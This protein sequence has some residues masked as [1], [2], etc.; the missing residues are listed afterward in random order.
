MKNI[1][2]FLVAAVAMFAAVSCNK[3]LTNNNLFGGEVITF[4]ASLDGADTKAQLVEGKSQWEANDAITVLNGTSGFKFTTASEGASVNFTYDNSK[5]D[6][7]GE[8]F[9][10]VYPASSGYPYSADLGDKTV[11]AYIPTW[12]EAVVDSYHKDAALSV[13]YTDSDALYFMNAVALL[14]FTVQNE[15][16]KNVTFVANDNSAVSGNVKVTLNSDGSQI[17]S[18]EGLPTSDLAYNVVYL[19]PNAWTSDDA[20]FAAYFFGASGNEWQ[21]MSDSDGDGVYEVAIPA[22]KNYSSVIFCRMK[23]DAKVNNWDNKWN[24]TVDLSLASGQIF[25]F[26]VWEDS[27]HENKSNGD[28][29]FGQPKPR[30]CVELQAKSNESLQ[31]GETYYMAV[32]PKV[33]EAGFSV[34]LQI[35]SEDKTT[36]KTLETSYDITPNMILNLGE[37]KYVEPLKERGLM[38]S[39]SS[40]TAYMG[41]E[42]TAPTLNGETDG[43]VYSSS[44]PEVAVVDAA[45]GIVTLRGAGTTVITASAEETSTYLAGEASYTLSVEKQ[46]RKLEFS[47]LSATANMGKEFAPPTLSGQTDG[48]VYSS[49]NPEV[50]VVDAVSGIVTLRGT[51]ITTITASAEETSTYLAGEVSYTLTVN[52]QE[53]GLA[54]SKD[55]V[56]VIAGSDFTL[57]TLSGVTDGVT[58]ESTKISVATVDT[59]G[60]VTLLTYGTTTITAT[61]EETDTYQYESVSYELEYSPATI[62]LYVESEKTGF[63]MKIYV[64][65]IEGAGLPSNWPGESLS[66]DS[67]VGKYYYDFPLDVKGKELSFLINVNG[68]DCKSANQK[69]K[70]DE[71]EKTYNLGWKWLYL[72]PNSNW[73]QSNAK[74]AA[75]FFTKNVSGEYWQWMMKL[76]GTSYYGCVI[77]GS[78]NNVIFCRMNSSAT[79]MN[80]DNKWNQTGDLTIPTDGKNL[81]TVPSSSWDGATSTWSKKSF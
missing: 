64:W 61:A 56:L 79:N 4:R 42:F 67:T 5:G 22:G 15:N 38:F 25:T 13:A 19:V 55:K 81:F 27:A 58:Y 9:I 45:S 80:W 6:F 72:N 36:V 10:A 2:S 51:G 12:Q 14:K 46:N 66:W 70:F 40:V 78:Y 50:A 54:F 30:T 31:V 23:P 33:Y 68:D 47:S 69:I 76:E 49:S 73:K 71:Y 41:K 26:K 44:K 32:A 24:Q 16:V 37:L 11:N 62:K 21:N 28:W 8:E 7:S 35:G 43:V 20:R 29:N 63:D 60:N 75:Y 57:P 3:E 18:V 34:Q 39:S 52:K 48:V 74:F 65:D 17:T 59:E 1:Y 53:R 77:P